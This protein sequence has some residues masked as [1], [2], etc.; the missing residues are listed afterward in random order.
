MQHVTATRMSLRGPPM[1]MGA[2]VAVLLMFGV[3]FAPDAAARMRCSFSGAPQN[4]LTVTADRGALG[5]ITR[6]G[7]RIVVREYL[8]RPSSCRG[9]VPTVRNTDTIRVL[10][11][12]VD[13]SVDVLLGGGP[14]APGATRERRGASE[15]EIRMQFRGRRNEGFGEV[16]GSRRADEFHWGPGPA[17]N[18]G[19]NINPRDAGDRDV[20]VTVRGA[21]TFLVA[22]GLAGNDT[23]VP[24]PGSQFPNDGVFSTG[25][26]GDD[27]L[28][29]P[30]NS[31]GIL[32]GQGGDDV[33]LGGRRGDD[34]QGGGG[35]DRLISDGGD[36]SI[37]AGPGHDLIVS[38]PGRDRIGSRDFKHLS[39]TP[40]PERD[41]V[42][43]GTNRDRVRP[44][45]RDRMRGCEVIRRR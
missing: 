3:S 21:D 32:E 38:G 23:I 27:H 34:F 43:C 13:D 11:R 35:H 22:N 30:R 12:G 37:R 1:F 5:E 41:W 33:L 8:E 10:S 39:P 14:F 15:I 42:D 40:D 2:V 25:G 9:G 17:K 45:R 19:L 44:D 4:L 18:A 29:A 6:N 31:W 28:I 36:D 26:P 7:R 20:D 24:A 16:W